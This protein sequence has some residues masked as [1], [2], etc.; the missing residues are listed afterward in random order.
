MIQKYM[1]IEELIIL[2]VIVIARGYYFSKRC[3][4]SV[5]YF[6]RNMLES[7]LILNEN[8]AKW[9]NIFKEQQQPTKQST[10]ERI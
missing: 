4:R 8:I 5:A 6:I 9:K 2:V 1:Q 7:S 10:T 3:S